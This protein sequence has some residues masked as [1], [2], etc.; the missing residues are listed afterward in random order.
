LNGF[1]FSIVPAM[2]PNPM[3]AISL[4]SLVLGTAAAGLLLSPVNAFTASP[5]AGFT[6]L[7]NGKDLSGWRGGVTFDHR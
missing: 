3:N 1:T 6:A 7:Y 5:P 2:F 4:R